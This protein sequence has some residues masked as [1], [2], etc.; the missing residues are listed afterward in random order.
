MPEPETFKSRK[1]AHSW[2]VEQG[3]AVSIGKFY[4]DI[5]EK[6]FPV[7]NQDKSVSKYQVAVYGRDLEGKQA[8]DPSALSRSEYTQQK[9]KAEAEMAVMKAERMRREEDELWLHAD[10]AWSVV[11]ALIGELRDVTRRNLHDEQLAIVQAS[12]GDP[13]RAPEV[14]EYVDQVVSRAFNQ[15][16]GDSLEINWEGDE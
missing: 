5:K 10:K 7:L 11:A 9:E 8:P 16:A 12:G 1:E 4:Q 15:V 14:F 3:Y 2:L 13:V 6:G